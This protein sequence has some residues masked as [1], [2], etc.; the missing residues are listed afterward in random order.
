MFFKRILVVL[1][2][3]ELFTNLKLVHSFHAKE[4]KQEFCYSSL[5]VVQLQDATCSFHS[6]WS[7]MAKEAH[8]IAAAIKKIDKDSRFGIATFGDK[9][10][11]NQI[12]G[13]SVPRRLGKEGDYCLKVELPLVN[14]NPKTVHKIFDEV[15]SVKNR[16][17]GGGDWDEAVF[18]AIYRLALTNKIQWRDYKSP[19][20]TYVSR[21]IVVV[22]DAKSHMKDD[23]QGILGK[24]L[25]AFETI[26]QRIKA[27]SNENIDC[28]SV[29]YPDHKD[30]MEYLKKNHISIVFLIAR[31]EELKAKNIRLGSRWINRRRPTNNVAKWYRDIFANLDLDVPIYE[32][33]M[34]ESNLASSFQSVLDEFQKKMCIK[35]AV[36]SDSYEKNTE[37]HDSSE[38][39]EKNPFRNCSTEEEHYQNFDNT[40]LFGKF[41]LHNIT[42]NGTI[43]LS[44][45]RKIIESNRCQSQTFTVDNKNSTE[46]SG[47]D[48]NTLKNTLWEYNQSH[49]AVNELGKNVSDDELNSVSCGELTCNKKENYVDKENHALNN[50]TLQTYNT[51]LNEF[52]T[53]GTSETLNTSVSGSEEKIQNCSI[54]HSSDC[55]NLVDALETAPDLADEVS[56]K[57]IK[58]IRPNL[59]G[60]TPRL[61]AEEVLTNNVEPALVEKINDVP[62]QP[63]QNVLDG[64]TDDVT[65][66]QVDNGTATFIDNVRS[67]PAGKVSTAPIENVSTNSI[68]GE[69]AMFVA[70]AATEPIKTVSTEP[71]D[72]VG[73]N[74]VDDKSTEPTKNGS[75]NSTDNSRI[76]LVNN[77]TA[78]SIYNVGVN[79]T[80]KVVREPTQYVS[81]EPTDNLRIG[82]VDNGTAPSVND[83][84]IKPVNEVSTELIENISTNP[85]DGEE[86]KPVDKA[87][88]KAIK[89]V[90]TEPT[91]NDET[92]PVGHKSIDPTKNVLTNKNDIEEAKSVDKAAI[93]PTKTVS[94]ETTNA[95]ETELVGDK[96][97]DPTEN[98][99]T[100]KTDIEEAQPVDEAAT[101][102]TKTL[103][104]E[105]ADD[106]GTNLVDDKS[107]EPT[108]NGPTNSTDNSGIE[109]FEDKIMPSINSVGVDPI[110]KVVRE[111]TDTVSTKPTYDMETEFVD[112]APK[113]FTK[114]VLT[115]PTVNA[116]TKVVDN[117]S[118][119][120]TDRV[121]IEPIDKPTTEPTQYVSREPTD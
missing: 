68:D 66:K 108:E 27:S 85:T 9:S 6:L 47:Q 56:T 39:V 93:E 77:E 81:R 40:L 17:G 102:F 46:N 15:A 91:D 1:V 111:P 58:V 79:S 97:T 74:L 94:T 87:L 110:D 45:R 52:S 5:D 2:V 48:E 54:F 83:V 55:A 65:K 20:G 92:E 96:S 36:E 103:L 75:T 88:T 16:K 73:T 62:I 12:L 69:K 38:S 35:I 43:S 42:E 100:N 105:I 80:D 50:S 104:T 120:P 89:P 33:D 61:S 3:S 121:E 11:K 28:L 99:S 22:T 37:V 114:N 112:E 70:K 23:V 86:G 90:S 25:P 63:A 29:E 71:T 117:V 30:V 82:L 32:F 116:A 113:K 78:I 7:S 107:T 84:N 44:S 49:D 4:N 67:E 57:S 53:L 18:E 119:K 34:Q 95:V 19:D 60:G 41:I 115:E 76:E 106:I 72:D 109:N 59:S 10:L 64:V 26:I 14:N 31:G 101:E 24:Q 8:S 51:S 118:T 21:V 13:E 98:V